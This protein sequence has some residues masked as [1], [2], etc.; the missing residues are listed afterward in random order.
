MTQLERLRALLA[1]NEQTIR[2]MKELRDKLYELSSEVGDRPDGEW[3]R[4]DGSIYYEGRHELR[5]VS[6]E[7]DEA[8]GT[9]CCLQVSARQ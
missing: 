7:L 4:D 3:D 1:V 2:E 9:L 5:Q 8:I 6:Q